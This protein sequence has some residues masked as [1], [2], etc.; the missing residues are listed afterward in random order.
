V[1]GFF[2]KSWNISGPFGPVDFKI[3]EQVESYWTNFAKTGDPNGPSLPK[4]PG[5]GT[6]Q[7]YISI[8]QD[9]SVVA[10]SGGLRRKQCELNRQILESREKQKTWK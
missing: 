6:S 10:N 9:G 7:N 3:A 1:F 2:P 5:F 8:S 4:W